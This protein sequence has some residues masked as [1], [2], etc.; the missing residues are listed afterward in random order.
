MK[1]KLGY[2]GHVKRHDTIEK[3]VLEGKIEGKRS[4]GKPRRAWADDVS[5]G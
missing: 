2:F 5:I 4:R 1:L 3:T